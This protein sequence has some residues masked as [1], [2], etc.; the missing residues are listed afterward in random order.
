M[1]N[2]EAS[3]ILL[4]KFNLCYKVKCA[5]YPDSIFWFYDEQFIRKQK[6]CKLNNQDVLLP[7]KINGYCLFEQDIKSMNLFCEDGLWDI[8]EECCNKKNIDIRTIIKYSLENYKIFNDYKFYNE[9]GS[10]KSMIT[11]ITKLTIYSNE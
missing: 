2:I 6:I 8:I 9:R 11:D 5:D 1:N 3:Y 10:F 7:K 4:N